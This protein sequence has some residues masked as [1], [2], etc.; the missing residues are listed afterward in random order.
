MYDHKC[1]IYT[2]KQKLQ[3][4]NEPLSIEEKLEINDRINELK[5][6]IKEMKYKKK[7]YLLGNSKYIFEYF[8]NKKNISSG[9]KTQT[10]TNKSKLVNIFLS[11]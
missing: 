7:N 11:N 10:V 5:E 4:E 2:L 8:E 9:I 6:I 3:L 1:E